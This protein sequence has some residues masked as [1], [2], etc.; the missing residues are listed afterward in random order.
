MTTRF[1][2]SSGNKTKCPRIAVTHVRNGNLCQQTF[3]RVFTASGTCCHRHGIHT[4]YDRFVV[5]G[6]TRLFAHVFTVRRVL[7]A[8]KDVSPLRPTPFLLFSQQNKLVMQQK[9]QPVLPCS[10]VT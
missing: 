9:W 7:D 3:A 5:N 4:H 1:P 2:L 10:C 6:I 8:K